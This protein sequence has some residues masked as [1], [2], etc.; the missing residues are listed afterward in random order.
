MGTL[1]TTNIQSISGSGTVTLG[2]AGETFTVTNGIMSGQNYPAFHARLSA[3]QSL[4]TATN[5]TVQCNQEAFDLGSCYNNTSGA[6]TLN[7]ISVPAYSFLPNL[8]GKYYV[9]GFVRSNTSATAAIYYALIQKNG[10]TNEFIEISDFTQYN[11]HRCGGLIEFN[12][13]S[14]YITLLAYQNSGGSI[15]LQGYSGL[16]EACNFGAFRIGA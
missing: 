13:T 16:D 2:V 8:A 11:S 1:K 15:T 10:S 9:Y 14:D 4:A 12:G 6:V 3:D 5:S 7:G